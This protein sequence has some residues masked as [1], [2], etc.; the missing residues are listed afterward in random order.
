MPTAEVSKTSAV[1][2][3]GR[4]GELAVNRTP[5]LT[6]RGASPVEQ[7]GASGLNSAADQD[8]NGDT[9]ADERYLINYPG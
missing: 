9:N 7:N 6:L 2:M 1:G 4:C 5:A 3:M 8:A